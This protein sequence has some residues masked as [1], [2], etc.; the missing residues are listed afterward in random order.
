MGDL[1]IMMRHSTTF[2]ALLLMCAAVLTWLGLSKLPAHA[3]AVT[4]PGLLN[5]GPG[6]STVGTATTAASDGQGNIVL[7]YPNG[8]VAVV[9]PSNID[10]TGK[11]DKLAA[12]PQ[13]PVTVYRIRTDGLVEKLSRSFP[14]IM[15]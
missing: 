8:I 4:N 5:S 2:C 1:V 9:K 7:T 11:P 13:S 3:Q 6:P 10:M 15:R 14:P 12:Q